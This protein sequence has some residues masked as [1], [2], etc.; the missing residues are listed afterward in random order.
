M[1]G[2]CGLTWSDSDLIRKMGNKIKHRGP[3]QE[4]FYVDEHVSLC[5]ERL[6]ILDLRETAKQPQHNEDSTIWVVL[7]GE[8]YNFRELR[9][10]L[11]QNHTFYTNSDTEVILHA[12]E[13]YGENCLQHLNGMFAFAIWDIKKKKLFLARDR[14]G[15]K[16]LYYSIVNENLLFSSEIKSILQ[17]DE[18]ERALNY[19]ALSQFLTYAYTIDGQT[20]FKNIFELLPGQKLVYYFDNK[21]PQISNYWNLSLQH[22]SDSED[23]ILKKLEKLLTKSIE[24]R[25]ESDAP[26]GA[27]LSGG[28]DS[29]IMVAILN[30]ITDTPVKTFTTGFGH[31]LDE[32]KEAKIVAEHCNT[33]HKEIELSYKKLTNSLPTI[34]WHMEFPFGRPSILSNF[35][36]AEEVKKFVTVAYTGEGSD[37]LFGGYNRYIPFSEKNSIPLNDKINSIPSGFFSNSEDRAIFSQSLDVHSLNETDPN[38]AFSK[39]SEKN[40]NHDL[41]NQ[42]LLFELKTE[43]PGAQTWRIDRAGSAHALELREPFLDYHLV[44][45]ASSIPGNYKI[46]FNNEIQKKHILQKLKF[47]WGI[48]YYDFFMNEFL[49]LAECLI[50]KGIKNHRPFLNSESNQLHNLFS[51]VSKLDDKNIKSKD[52]E[53]N[54]KILRQIMFI[55]NLELWYQMFIEN[56]NIKN[57]SLSINNFI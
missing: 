57:P 11:E 51:N 2:I 32:Y 30:N 40:P 47:P 56:D 46:A 55:F 38:V 34:L 19:S 10:K 24:I 27:L 4:G 29:S 43:I 14:L 15:V 5:C 18:V 13:E 21:K 8:I 25:L 53:I 26:V 33:E 52:V 35:L 16:P 36:V 17:H 20:L 9:E 7:N 49:P 54:D 42:V 45:Y 22:S 3:E 41:L 28:L 23:V 6:K 12:Y 48:P 31:E 37:E 39:I 1:C 50:D 44:E